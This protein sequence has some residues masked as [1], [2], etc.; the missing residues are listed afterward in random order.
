[1]ATPN[2]NEDSRRSADNRMIANP[3]EAAC[4]KQFSWT[5]IGKLLSCV[6]SLVWLIMLHVSTADSGGLGLFAPT[7]WSKII[8][9]SI[10]GAAIFPILAFTHGWLRYAL[11]LPFVLLSAWTI[12][13]LLTTLGATYPMRIPH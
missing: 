9:A 6:L 4:R 7:V 12:W 5:R 8:T 1:M 11:G 13:A 2:P 10:T 3:T